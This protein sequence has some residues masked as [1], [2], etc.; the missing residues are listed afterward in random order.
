[1]LILRGSQALSDF[2]Q[3]HLLRTLNDSGIPARALRVDFVHLVRV[4]RALDAAELG[5]LERLLTYGPRREGAAV[6]G[7]VLWVSPRRGTIS[8]WSS[9][10]TDIVRICGLVSV[11]RVERILE[12]RL[13]L[14]GASL[15]EAEERVL[16]AKLH[17]RMTQEVFGEWEA[18]EGLF[19]QQSPRP[20]QT[21]PV[22]ARGRGA[23]EEANAVLGLA[24]A[25]DEMR[26][27][28]PWRF[29]N[30]S[31][32]PSAAVQSRSLI[33]LRP[34]AAGE[35][36]TFDYTTTEGSM[37]EPFTCLCGASGCVGTVRGFA[38]LS[39]AEQRARRD[40]LAPH[41]R[42]LLEQPGPGRTADAR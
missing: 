10:A 28:H 1:M 41:L 31:C 6:E 21:V 9:K 26:R 15:G 27:R 20:L 30:H 25:D 24:L 7:R 14:G 33:A 4:S 8:P 40:R 11:E 5:A 34:I 3:N 19:A 29:L 2:R 17:D 39:A 23:L 13:D 18:L 16:R 35:Q 37:A 42:A 32:D 36:I 12:Y 22:L 38:H